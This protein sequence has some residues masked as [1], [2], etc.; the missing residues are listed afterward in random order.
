MTTATRHIVS[1]LAFVILVVTQG[2][3]TTV[4]TDSTTCTVDSVMP[5]P[6]P[7]DD[8]WLIPAGAGAGLVTLGA[9]TQHSSDRWSFAK[10]SSHKNGFIEVAQYIPVA[11]PW[12]MKALGQP[13]RSGWGRMA[14]SQATAIAIM[15]GSVYPLKRG[16]DSRR[17]DDS[18]SHSFPSGHSAWAFMGATMTANE[19]A[20]KS[21]WYPF[22]AYTLATAVAAERVIN[23]RHYP[24]D[25]IAGAGIGILSAQ[26]G[27]FVGDLI[28]GNRQLDPRSVC[29]LHDNLNLSFLSLNIG[30]NLPLGRIAI[31][32]GKI[33][34]LPALSAG[35]H[36]GFAIGDNWGI[37]AEVGLISTPIQVEERYDRT[38]VAPLT[39]LGAVISP[40][41]RL[42]LSRRVSFSADIG[43]GYYHNFRL[44]SIDEA[45]KAGNGTP[46]GRVNV[47]TIL[48]LSDH[49]SCKASVGY[50]ISRYD[51]TIKQSEDYHLTVSDHSSG[52]TGSLLFSLSSRVEF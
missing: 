5:T 22:G 48:R 24:T 30:L 14:T 51:F 31:G 38:H 4:H 21:P 32:N 18:D 49:F 41:Y 46:V 16:I 33:I 45:V 26:L 47:G 20:W 13:T 28:F 50:Q 25:V 23:S 2:K 7:S 34:R 29:P 6:K 39:S 9:A 43:A 11:L 27:Y 19:L 37:G 3:A 52:T 15:A 42:A 17:P 35:F 36:G 40:Y 10:A 8:T 1:A 12:A 44:N